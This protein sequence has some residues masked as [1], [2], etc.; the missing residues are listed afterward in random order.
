MNTVPIRAGGGGVAADASEDAVA[1]MPARPAQGGGAEGREGDGGEGGRGGDGACEGAH[2]KDGGRDEE[3]GDGAQGQGRG[4]AGRGAVEAAE[5]PAQDRARTRRVQVLAASSHQ[6]P[7]SKEG[8]LS[9]R[10]LAN[11]MYRCL[12]TG[13]IHLI[14]NAPFDPK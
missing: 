9:T 11:D 3:D 1:A 4:G 14:I 10:H 5:I 7:P 13:D 6:G 12:F 8:T 2:E